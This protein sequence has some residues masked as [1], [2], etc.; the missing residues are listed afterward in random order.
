MRIIHTSDWHLGRQFGPMSL[1]ADQEAFCDWIVELCQDQEA[2]LVVVAGDLFDRA[3]A[4]VESIELFR[5]TV[6]RLLDQGVMVA[7]ITGNHDG[8]DR[9]VPHGDLLDLSR[10]YLRGGYHGVGGVVSIDA[11]DGPLDLVLL[12]FLDPQAA[13]DDFGEVTGGGEP[14]DVDADADTDELVDRR[15]RRTHRSVLEV[16][17]A[18]ASGRLAAPRSL[19]VAHAFV[20]GGESSDSERQLVVGGTGEVPVDLFEPFSYTAL[21]HLHR[22]QTV[23]GKENVRYSGTP[24]AY[25]FS[26]EHAKSVAVVDMDPEGASTVETIPVDVGRPVRRLTGPIDELLDPARHPDAHNCFVQATLTD[27][28]T[29]LDAKTRL[30]EVYPWVVEVRLRAAELSDEA[31]DAPTDV[32]DL[33]TIDVTRLFYEAAEGAPPD[34]AA[35]EVLVGAVTRATAEVDR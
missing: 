29:V 17:C 1:R 32:T 15:Q 12:P 31:S 30:A 21:G 19:A 35:D 25:S 10:F 26:E 34:S 18:Q 7:A 28:S 5:T 33:S 8:A 6:R 14:L 27:R 13:P 16:A 22:P 24:L 4:P 23:A 2:E 3:I 9:V 20:A 11:S